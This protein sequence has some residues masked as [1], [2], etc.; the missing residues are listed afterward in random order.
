MIL[1]ALWYLPGLQQFQNAGICYALF[2]L[3]DQRQMDLICFF[4][5]WNLCDGLI[6]LLNNCRSNNDGH[7]D[8]SEFKYSLRFSSFQEMCKY[9]KDIKFLDSNSIDTKL[10]T[11]PIKPIHSDDL[12]WEIVEDPNKIKLIYLPE[13]D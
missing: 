10:K 6:Y 2:L 12:E 8:K 1:G 4:H 7:K 11:M 5:P 3:H 9:C 13:P